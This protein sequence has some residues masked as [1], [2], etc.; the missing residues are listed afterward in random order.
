MATLSDEHVFILIILTTIS[1]IMS[2]LG[3]CLVFRFLVQSQK[4]SPYTRMM[5]AMAIFEMERSCIFMIS[6]FL[7]PKSGGRLW[8]QGNHQTCTMLG[9][10]T[11]LGS[12]VPLYN[13]SLNIYYI[14][15]IIYTKS[16][17]QF[18]RKI[19][20][21]LHAV[22]I[23]YPLITAS[24]GAC[25]QFYS[26]LELGLTCWVGDFPIG[27]EE[28][29][30]VTCFG[31]MIGWIFAGIPFIASAVFLIVSNFIIFH[32]VNET[33]RRTLRYDMKNVMLEFSTKRDSH[34]EGSKESNNPLRN[35]VKLISMTNKAATNDVRILGHSVRRQEA[36]SD[37]IMTLT[38][39]ELKNDRL[40]GI[41][42][43]QSRKTMT[44]RISSQSRDLL[45]TRLVGRQAILHIMACLNS[46]VW[47]AMLRILESHGLDREDESNIYWMSLLAQ[48]TYPLQ[49]FWNFL[50]FVH[51]KYVR[52]RQ[53]FPSKSKWWALKRCCFL[54]C[55]PAAAAN[56][57]N[58][59]GMNLP[60]PS[61]VSWKESYFLRS[62]ILLMESN[63][64]SDIMLSNDMVD[65]GSR[66]DA[67]A[68]EEIY[69]I[70]DLESESS[71]KIPSA[72]VFEIS[73]SIWRTAAANDEDHSDSASECDMNLGGDIEA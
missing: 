7:L 28:K 43:T 11:Q 37:N 41:R 18:T 20:S 48:I 68:P 36:I 49:G 1:S 16:E 52:I 10:F 19:E 12:A 27:C 46:T 72:L 60:V 31:T 61:S 57:R 22:S 65:A 26:E 8:A 50:I 42:P 58:R 15:T 47:M 62:S 2:I 29:P 71:T 33:N 38:V 64:H 23:S 53:E 21:I 14:Y 54:N 9:F 70:T 4:R 13:I 5:M 55:I 24:L 44:I 17:K 39:K 51:P 6:P 40:T 25:G 67:S 45:R 66:N 56:R 73:D 3:S 59:H 69:R 34:G 63:H 30:G 35:F 32:K